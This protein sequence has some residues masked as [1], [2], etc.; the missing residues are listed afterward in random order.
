[1]HHIGEAL[2]AAAVVVAAVAAVVSEAVLLLALDL[3]QAVCDVLQLLRTKN[4][5]T[6]GGREA[7]IVSAV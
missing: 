3:S 2:L 6:R 5:G 7:N 1:M 4:G